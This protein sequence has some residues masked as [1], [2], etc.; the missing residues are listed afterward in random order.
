M[1]PALKDLPKRWKD[2]WVRATLSVV[3][4]ALFCFIIWMGLFAF[5]F[6]II[7][8]QIKSYYEIISV[9]YQVYKTFSFSMVRSLSWF[10]LMVVNYFMYFEMIASRF[11]TLIQSEEIYIQLQQYHRLISFC[12]YLLGFVVFVLSLKKGFYRMQFYMFA[13]TH[14]ALL[15]I[16]VQ[17]HLLIQNLLEGLIWLVVPCS[18]VICNDIMA[19]ICGFFCGKTPLI[20]L[21]PKKTWEGF[22]GGGIFT[23][24]CGWILSGYLSQFPSLT[25]PSEVL[26]NFTVTLSNEHMSVFQPKTYEIPLEII[27]VLKTLGLN[28]E[29]ITLIPFQ[30]HTLVISLF[31]SLIAP[32]GGF[33]ASGLKRAFKIKDFSDTIPGHGGMVDR[34]D[35]QLLVATFVTVY[36]HTFIKLPSATTLFYKV[37]A[38]STAEQL[39]LFDD[40][41]NSL[42]EAGAFN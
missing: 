39:Q 30:L 10:F 4:L 42:Q 28:L 3:M 32:F 1:K 16:V 22:I 5:M 38:L 36:L 29:T 15:L 20:K 25:C 7:I 33:F 34:F 6:A 14:L 37:V 24:I 18:L 12:M 11:S 19:Y 31:A 17:S 26:S 2:W 23:I 9:S 41:K 27:A 8:L 40:L 35:C 13:W 21:S